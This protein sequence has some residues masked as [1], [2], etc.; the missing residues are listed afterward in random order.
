VV[1]RPSSSGASHNVE[2]P[3]IESPIK[4]ARN[5]ARRVDRV[6][7]RAVGVAGIVTGRA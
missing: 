5:G 2:A 1:A 7:G 3:A 4:S 6:V